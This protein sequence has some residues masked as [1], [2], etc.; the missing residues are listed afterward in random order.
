MA[1]AATTVSAAM[2]GFSSSFIPYH[3]SDCQTDGHGYDGKNNNRTHIN[4][5]I[6]KRLSV[7]LLLFYAIVNSKR[8]EFLH[9]G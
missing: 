3:A 7:F 2:Q 8:Y 9:I 6:S 1:A 4:S 5:L